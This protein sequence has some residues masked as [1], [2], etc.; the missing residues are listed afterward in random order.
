MWFADKFVIYIPTKKYGLVVEQVIA[1]TALAGG[2]TR[3]EAVG[4][5]VMDDGTLCTEPMTL[6][7]F[8]LTGAKRQ[9]ARD[10][11]QILVNMLTASGEEC[12]LVEHTGTGAELMH[13]DMEDVTDGN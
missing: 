11:I 4:S 3:T 6:V 10:Q 7:A 9:R 12:V 13:G 5:Y 8:F 1:L 2:C